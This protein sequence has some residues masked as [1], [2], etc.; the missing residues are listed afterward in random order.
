[1]AK[2]E[3]FSPLLDKT[4][5]DIIYLLSLDSRQSISD[6]ARTLHIS[7]RIV[8]QRY[9]KIFAKKYVKP[10][11]IANF[12]N[13]LK[14][15]V[16]LK[17]V[18]F[19]TKILEEL[20]KIKSLVKAK[21]TLGQYD[22]SLLFFPKHKEELDTIL[23]HINTLCHESLQNIDVVFHEFEDTLGY[24]SFCHK[25]LFLSKYKMLTSQKITLGKQDFIVVEELL[26]N[27]LASTKE[28]MNQTQL[29]YKTITDT[30]HKFKEQASLR[31]SVD[32]DYGKLGLEFHNLLVKI[33]LGKQS[34]FENNIVRN[35][36]VHWIKRG[37][38]SWDYIL[39]IPAQS[40]SEFI[41]ITR[42]IRATN[43]ESILQCSALISKIHV[44]RKL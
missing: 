28:I 38:G 1:M 13:T 34:L 30:L 24:K 5:E 17:L 32:P 14:V 19:D 44:E 16:F 20:K 2:Y 36:R 27:P 35:Q 31:F 40:I 29:G 33:N 43:R 8:E 42:D 26:R 7:R 21:E 15:T 22:L 12:A 37:T 11:L 41:D 3:N 23:H 6:L 39:S 18:P 25:P 9:N 10:L 4:S